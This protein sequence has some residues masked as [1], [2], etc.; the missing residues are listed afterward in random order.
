MLAL[1]AALTL[2]LAPLAVFLVW[3]GGWV[4][5]AIAVVGLAGAYAYTGPP[6]NL[7]YHALGE[8][9]IFMVFGPAI[10]AGAAYM[11]THRLEPRALMYS[12]PVGM[13]IVAIV[14]SNFLRDIEEDSRSGILTLANLL[15]RRRYLPVYLAMMFAPPILVILMVVAKAAPA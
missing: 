5:A 10:A 13:L 9:C 6:L 12:I 7:K 3:K 11:Q 15:G 2:L 8:L 1:V 14:S 4:A